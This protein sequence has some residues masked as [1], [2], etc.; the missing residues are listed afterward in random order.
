LIIVVDQDLI[1]DLE[2]SNR[3]DYW[4]VKS[5]EKPFDHRYKRRDRRPLIICGHGA[6]L[7]VDRGTLFVKNGFTHYPQA[8]EE[9]RYFRGEPNLP[10]RIIIIDA[11]GSIT[12]DVLEW[13][14]SQKI[15]L[16][17]LNWQGDLVCVANSNY[18]A[19]PK[20]VEKQIKSLKNGDGQKQF[21]QLILKKFQNSNQ[22]LKMLP[23][24]GARSEAIQYIRSM[25]KKLSDDKTIRTDILLG[26]EGQAAA[27]YFAVWRGIP[28]KWKLSKKAIIPDDWHNIGTRR[29]V[30][31]TINRNARHPVNA[32]LNYAYAILQ[33]HIKMQIIS[34][35]L[36]PTIG[37]SHT[38]KE[39]R[40]SLVMDRMEPF[41][42]IV[43]REVLKLVIDSTLVPDDFTITNE[44]FCRLNPQLARK[45]VAISS[46]IN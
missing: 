38:I 1:D 14:N 44:G 20:L 34:E 7:N 36:D 5:Q 32:M 35:G 31:G 28:I 18:S 12:F 39:Y 11:S 19:D 23:N 30:V 24:G 6:R 45:V 40:D 22:T 2:W 27:L 33:A 16:V 15:P 37:L 25:I 13:L 9:F 46:H 17:H 3:C 10:E 29:S 42:P 21:Q 26:I 8:R 4:H 41:R 43:D